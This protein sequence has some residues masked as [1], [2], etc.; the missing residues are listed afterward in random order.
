ML[1][2]NENNRVESLEHSIA[3]LNYLRVYVFKKVCNNSFVESNYWIND[4]YERRG[5]ADGVN[6]TLFVEEEFYENHSNNSQ[7][8]K[9]CRD[10]S[11][12]EEVNLTPRW[13]FN[14][15]SRSSQFLKFETPI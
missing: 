9:N 13:N 11:F 10:S 8:T 7:D 15:I 2:I 6:D 4:S 14:V 12:Q 5:D 1:R 3:I